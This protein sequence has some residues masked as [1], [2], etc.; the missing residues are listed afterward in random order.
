MFS[1]FWRFSEEPVTEYDSMF[2]N[3][4]NV[5]LYERYENVEYALK[6]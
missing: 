1:V 2:A 3:G 4:E 5:Y 6:I